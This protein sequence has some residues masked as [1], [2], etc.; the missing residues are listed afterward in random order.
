M[1]IKDTKIY[2]LLLNMILKKSCLFRI[3][4]AYKVIIVRLDEFEIQY[5][6]LYMEELKDEN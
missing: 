2:Q 5:N 3:E 1:G 6:W 4:E